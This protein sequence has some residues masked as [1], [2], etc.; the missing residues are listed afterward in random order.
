MAALEGLEDFIREKIEKEHWTHKELSAH[1]QHAYPGQRGTSV[2]SL[3]RFCS[4]KGIHKT[5]RLSTQHLDEVV[6]DAIAKVRKLLQYDMHIPVSLADSVSV[7]MR[8]IDMQ[9]G[10]TYGRK[11]MTGLLASQGLHVSQ[12]RVGESLCRTNPRLKVIII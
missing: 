5:A 3:E 7:L 8:N 11:K 4:V 6:S 2:L 10:P 1:L 12:R 9:V